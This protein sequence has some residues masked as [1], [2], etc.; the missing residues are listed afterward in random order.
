MNGDKKVF[1]WMQPRDKPKWSR[2]DYFL[3]SESL[4]T[5]CLKSEILPSISTDHSL[6]TLEC[7][8]QECKRGPGLWKFNN[9]LLEDPKFVEET[10]QLLQKFKETYSFMEPIQKWELLKFE[11][12]HLS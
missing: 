3:I 7:N 1:T 4:R 8:L 6:I 5:K 12:A 2:I 9:E 11:V 10:T